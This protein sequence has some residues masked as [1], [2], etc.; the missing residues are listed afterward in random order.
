MPAC[1]FSHLCQSKADL[2]WSPRYQ[3]AVLW[4]GDSNQEKETGE[5]WSAS[6]TRKRNQAALKWGSRFCWRWLIPLQCL[7][8]SRRRGPWDVGS[9]RWNDTETPRGWRG[10]SAARC[11]LCTVFRITVA[12]TS[13]PLA[14]PR[15]PGPFQLDVLA[16]ST[17]SGK[18]W[19]QELAG[20]PGAF[21][22]LLSPPL[23]SSCAL[24]EIKCMFSSKMS[25][26]E[27][28]KSH[29][30]L[31]SGSFLQLTSRLCQE[32]SSACPQLTLAGASSMQMRS[33]FHVCPSEALVS[34][35]E[36]KEENHRHHHWQKNPQD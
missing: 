35:K 28:R 13:H 17:K 3:T 25:D 31:K 33:R 22:C 15:T 26:R 23:P 18:M 30:G 29:P 32:G 21:G 9:S 19:A 16:S 1:P 12:I 11:Q 34:E 27:Q 2:V 4:E 36:R 20:Q 5:N 14:W 8:R 7:A 10:C 24:F 6:G